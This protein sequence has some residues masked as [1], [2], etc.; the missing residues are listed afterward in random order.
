LLQQATR[1]S[2]MACPA[3]RFRRIYVNSSRSSP[4]KK[5]VR[6]IC[7]PAGGRMDFSVHNAGAGM[8]MN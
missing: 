1:G 8:L 7:S 2:V 5:R 4:R 3:W 6:D